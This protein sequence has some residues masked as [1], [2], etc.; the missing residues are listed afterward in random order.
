MKQLT[1]N[2]TWNDEKDDAVARAF[3]TELYKKCAESGEVTVGDID[4]CIEI[5]RPKFDEEYIK[6]YGEIDDIIDEII[7]EAIGNGKVIDN[8]AEK[9]VSTVKA[10]IDVADGIKIKL[11]TDD[12]PYFDWRETADW[13][14]KATFKF[15]RIK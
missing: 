1:F 12:S 13:N 5:I 6:E 15:G 10:T 4:A 3:F 8:D 11:T 9:C 7:S 14:W 2:E